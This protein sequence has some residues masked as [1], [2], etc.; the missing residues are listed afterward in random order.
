MKSLVLQV[1]SKEFG[2]LKALENISLSVEEGERLAILGPNGAGKTT[3]FNVV[4]GILRPS[5]GQIHLFDTNVTRLPAHQRAALG[6]GRTFQVTSLFRSLSVRDNVML[7]LQAHL[8]SKY[9]LHRP[10]TSDDSSWADVNKLLTEWNIQDKQDIPVRNLS[11]GDQRLL[12]IVMA[13]AGIPKVLLLDEPTAGL[14]PAETAMMTRVIQN[15][16]PNITLLLIEH[17]MDVAFQLASRVIVLH[18][19]RVLA[20]GPSELVRGDP[21]VREIYLGE[22]E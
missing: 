14:S 16:D 3:L 5:S 18:Q 9:V 7:A 1:L 20:D 4:S 21:R 17:D 22:S 15:L 6:L 2:G 13:I 12:E 8:P 11:Y 19:G 10:I